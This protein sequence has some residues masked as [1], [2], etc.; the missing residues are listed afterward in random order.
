MR[1]VYDHR[2]IAPRRDDLEPPLDALCA[3][4]RVRAIGKAEAER[5]A[6]GHG[7][8]RVVDGEHAGNAE[9]RHAYL[10]A[11]D[12]GETY[13]VGGE[14]DV[15][16]D[17]VGFVLLSRKCHRAAGC[18][19]A[20]EVRPCVVKIEAA[21]G[22]HT[23]QL[24]FR[25]GVLLH[26]PVEIEMI[27]RE[28]CIECNVKMYSSHALKRQRV[29]G[30]LHHD[31]RAARIRHMAEE[32]VQLVALRRR[33]LGV[34][35]LVAYHVPVRADKAD[36]R[37]KL[38]L[39]HVLYQVARAGLS[40]GSGDADHRHLRGGIAEEV[41][42]DYRKTI[43]RIGYQDIGYIAGRL[44]LAE[45]HRR[46]VFNGLRDEFVPVGLKAAYCDEHIPFF[47]LARIIAH[48]AYLK[49]GVGVHF[50]YAQVLYQLTKFHI[51]L[52]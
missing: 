30:H 10:V 49:L 23:E 7:A 24:S 26:R 32:L 52:L 5:K 17:E 4:H 9:L 21:E 1:I 8:E 28:I 3:G 47:R 14:A 38:A 35:K 29:G 20:H 50:Y 41:A 27:L 31:M 22:A 33:V 36:L 37:V 12:R 42:A 25:C 45:D 46:A 40:A 6:D 15:L 39:E 16:C 43:A 48:A 11:A 13:T 18:A 51:F 44:L 19:A 34:Q 2:E